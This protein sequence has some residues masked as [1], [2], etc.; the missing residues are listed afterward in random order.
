MYSRKNLSFIILISFLLQG[1]FLFF[2]GLS[3]RVDARE[4]FYI[5]AEMGDDSNDGMSE[6]F[7]WKTLR[8][9]N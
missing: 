4:I 6:S 7:P 2:C 9:I 1:M 3:S 5:D 8:N